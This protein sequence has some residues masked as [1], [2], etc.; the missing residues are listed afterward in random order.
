MGIAADSTLPLN[1][2]A[3]VE[4]GRVSRVVRVLPSLTD[5]AF[6]LPILFVFGG[7][8]GAYSL[9]G[10]ADT[11]WHLRTGEWILANGRVPRTDIF[12]YT[13]P[14]EPWFAWEWGWDVLFARLYQSFGMASVVLASMLIISLTTALLFRLGRRKADNLFVAFAVTALAMADSSLRWRD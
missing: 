11:G 14:G 1:A 4:A 13:R 3:P 6:I 9:L 10:D 8:R 12:S 7:M 2:P 5:V